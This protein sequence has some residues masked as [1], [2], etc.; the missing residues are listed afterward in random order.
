M[1][2]ITYYIFSH[3]YQILLLIIHFEAIWTILSIFL[4][5]SPSFVVR[6][7]IDEPLLLLMKKIN[8]Y[9]STNYKVSNRLIIKS[10]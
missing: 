1:K 5:R 10:Y 2:F 4:Y 7:F 6:L 8:V 9:V 3:N